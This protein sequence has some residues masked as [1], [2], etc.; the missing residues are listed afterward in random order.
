MTCPVR[1]PS[2]WKRS[3]R[4]ADGAVMCG[5]D[6]NGYRTAL[7]YE[8]PNS[9]ERFAPWYAAAQFARPRTRSTRLTTRGEHRPPTTAPPGVRRAA[10]AHAT[11]APWTTLLPRSPDRRNGRSTRRRGGRASRSARRR[12]L[13]AAKGHLARR[14]Q[15]AR[16][17]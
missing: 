6:G 14:S 4:T 16:Q 5:P 11:E 9:G 13:T 7:E 17:A 8:D 12:R 10:L 15:A 1:W 2:A 3:M